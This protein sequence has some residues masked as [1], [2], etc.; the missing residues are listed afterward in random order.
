ML[1]Q[2]AFVIN[3]SDANVPYG[4][5]GIGTGRSGGMPGQ[6]NTALKTNVI[7]FGPTGGIGHTPGFARGDSFPELN[8]E[9]YV[10]N[11]IRDQTAKRK[12][13]DPAGDHPIGRCPPRGSLRRR[14]RVDNNGP[15]PTER[16][17]TPGRWERFISDLQS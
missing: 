2:I 13:S 3:G 4:V 15:Q 7:L 17:E 12:E 1:S 16:S 6:C 8:P 14:R 9:R 10:L 5:G 11:A